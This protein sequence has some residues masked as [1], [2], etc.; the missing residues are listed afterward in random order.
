MNK[1]D[2]IVKNIKTKETTKDIKLFDAK[3]NIQRN[4]KRAIVR[5]KDTVEN[6]MDDKKVSPS[7]YAQDRVKYA[8]ADAAQRTFEATS[9]GI[10]V[11][12]G[13]SRK[14]KQARAALGAKRK[15]AK[16]AQ[17]TGK[18]IKQAARSMGR[19]V[20]EAFESLV[21]AIGAGG[22][23]AVAAVVIICGVGI[24]FGS[25][26]GIFFSSEDGSKQTM[27]SVVR[28]INTEYNDQ[29][30]AIKEENTYDRVT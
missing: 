6:L 17:A 24:I 20:R 3:A 22:V 12:R 23:I 25:A 19:A 7:E 21:A 30:Q 29:L 27:E 11:E 8:A 2:K 5:T 18:S 14:K 9:D 1:G 4:I 26:F 10:R 28:E 13:R 16:A 15:A